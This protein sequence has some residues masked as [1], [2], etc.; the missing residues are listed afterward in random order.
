MFD[1]SVDCERLPHHCVRGSVC[2]SLVLSECNT[3]G[4]YVDRFRSVRLRL[5]C[6]K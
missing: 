2:F 5:C 4:T 6:V 3:Y 1:I